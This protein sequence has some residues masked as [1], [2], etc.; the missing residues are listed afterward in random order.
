MAKRNTRPTDFKEALSRVPWTSRG[1]DTPISRLA[2]SIVPVG[3]QASVPKGD[4]SLHMA[5]QDEAH[6]HIGLD[7]QGTAFQAGR[8]K[9]YTCWHVIEALRFQEREAY[10]LANTRLNGVEAQRPY[11]FAAIVK[12]YDM[13]FEDGG[14][15]ID[16]G[17]LICPATETP[18]FPYEVPPV[19]WGDSTRV[20]VG[21]RVLI[22]RFPLGWQM[23]FA[24]STNRGLI[25]PSFFDGIISAIIPAIR[26]GETRLFQIS[27][28]ALN[29]ISGGV[30]CDP[31]TG[32]VLGMV[33]SG[34]TS[35]EIDLPIT[36]ALPS[37]VLRPFA[38]AISFDVGDGDP[39][40]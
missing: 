21:D 35:G 39:W 14:P 22:G 33:T 28:V 13:R 2:R 20:G 32:V 9:L 26:P 18:E 24:N 38:D 34:L 36:Y 3:N 4:A 15:G 19:T 17:I 8:G 10:L 5:I 12:Y 25:Q 11:P 27:S 1:R 16:S 23:F 7:I 30:V 31:R 40:K 29:G 37:E 6:E